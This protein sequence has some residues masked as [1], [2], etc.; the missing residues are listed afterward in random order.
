MCVYACVISFFIFFSSEH[1]RSRSAERRSRSP[2]SSQAP[3]SQRSQSEPNRRRFDSNNIQFEFVE[4][5]RK[6]SQMLHTLGEEHLY[7]GKV[8]TKVGKQYDCYHSQDLG[9]KAKVFVHE[10]VCF[11]KISARAGESHNHASNPAEIDE[12]KLITEMKN[13]CSSAAAVTEMYGTHGCASSRRIFQSTLL[14]QSQRFFFI[15]NS[16]LF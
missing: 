11:R 7:R 9:C 2:V 12:M 6:G 8:N 13:R 14:R 5:K 16:L 3:P 15:L 1:R 4:G 10:G